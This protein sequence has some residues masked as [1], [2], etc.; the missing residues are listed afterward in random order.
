MS[1]ARRCTRTSPTWC[2]LQLQ[3][4]WRIPTESLW[5]IHMENPYCSCEPTR[6]QSM[7]V[8]LQ[9]QYGFSIGGCLHQ[10]MAPAVHAANIDWPSTR[11]P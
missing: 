1:S 6:L 11:W 10:H 2:A 4:L 9:L 8:G 3:S 5:R 7:G